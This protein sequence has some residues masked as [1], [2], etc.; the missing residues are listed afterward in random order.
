MADIV[1]PLRRRG[2]PRLVATSRERLAL[3]AVGVAAGILVLAGAEWG[4]RVAMARGLIEDEGA[5]IVRLQVHSERLGW[6]PTPGVEDDEDPRARVT[7]NARG[8]RGRLVPLERAPGIRRVVLLGDSVAFGTGVADD[9][10]FAAR[11]ASPGVETINLAVPGYGIDQSLLRLEQEGLAYHPD[12]VVL[13]LCVEN[14]LADNML[15][16]YLY[17]DRVPKP[18]FTLEGEG[19]VLHDAHLRLGPRRWLA[20]RLSESSAL[21]RWLVRPGARGGPRPE[22][23]HWAELRE[24]ALRD[25]VAVHRLSA[26]LLRRLQG[27]VES[28]GA[29]LVIA[30]HPNRSSYRY[31]DARLDALLVGEGLRGVNIVELRVFYRQRGVGFGRIAL[32]EVGHLTVEGH[33]LAAEALAAAVQAPAIAAGG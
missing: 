32:D 19:L 14:D 33:R 9:E 11:L 24:T 30:V 6:T 1:T 2:L 26:A 22:P 17:D 21:Y 7:I 20:T 18:Y 12:V 28:V 25:D 8:Y 13:N 4:V 16:A 31:G 3:A 23:T 15:R 27:D 29:R 10:T 5:G